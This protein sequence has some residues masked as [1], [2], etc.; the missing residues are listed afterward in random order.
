MSKKDKIIVE[1]I[2]KSTLGAKGHFDYEKLVYAM[3]CFLPCTYEE[4]L[5]EVVFTYDVTGMKPA[6]ELKQ[7]EKE[8]QYQFLIN[9][10]IMESLLETYKISLREENLYYDEN[11]LPYIKHRDLYNKG[12]GKEDGMFLVTYKIFIGGILSKKYGLKTLQESGLELLKQEAVFK[13]FY[14]A[15]TVGELTDVLRQRKNEYQQRIRS[16]TVRVK[17]KTH[18]VKTI[19]SIGASVL[20]AAAALYLGYVSVKVIPFQDKVIEAYQGYTANDY[21]EC[22]DSMKEIQPAQMDTSTKYI[23]AIAYAKSESLKKDEMDDIIEK[24]SLS[25]N[26]K[27]LEYWIHLGRL[28][29]QEAQSLAKALSNDKLLIYAYMKELNYLESSTAI[30]GEAKESRIS[31]LEQSIK[32]LGEKYSTNEPEAET[33]AQSEENQREENSEEKTAEAAGE[34]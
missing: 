26:E 22:I 14:E 13:E 30:E 20:F 21:V 7:E 2:K 28:E 34:E 4:G 8:V 23:L 27:E 19:I 18:Q 12:E 25:S 24:L 1:S 29:A 6:S 10:H 32:S 31:Q 17:K 3:P 16:T 33:E 11:F 5:E 15:A 9:F